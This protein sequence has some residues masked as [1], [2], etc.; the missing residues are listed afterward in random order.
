MEKEWID[1]RYA[2]L[3]EAWKRAR[4][5]S[6]SDPKPRPVRMFVVPRP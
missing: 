5:P 6:G 3:V 1:P 4:Q 2:K